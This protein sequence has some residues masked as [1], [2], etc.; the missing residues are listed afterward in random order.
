[1]VRF[2]FKTIFSRMLFLQCI[3]VF[4][5]LLITGL[6]IGLVS[7]RQGL[8]MERDLLLETAQQAF[9][10]VGQDREL[11]HFAQDSDTFIQIIENGSVKG[12]YTNPLWME[13]A[14]ID[15]EQTRLQEV[16][17]R[18]DR[19]PEGTE[20]FFC[21]SPFPIYTLYV[22]PEEG[23]ALILV[24]GDISAQNA[25]FSQVMTWTMAICAMAAFV[26]LLRSY[27]VSK[28]ILNPFVEMNHMVQCY[29]RGDFSQRIHLPGND[30]A[31]QL[32]RSFNEMADQLRNLEQTRQSFVA[33]VSHE[34]R[35]PLTSMKGFLEAM[36][37]GTIP[38]EDHEQY[39]GIVLSETRR[40]TAM[41]NDLL[42]LA[43][44]ESGIITVNY[45]VFDINE[46]IRRT[47][48][49]FEARISEKSIE[50]DVRFALEQC[51]VYADS[52]QISQVIRNL[53]DNAIKYSPDGSKLFV[54][55][56]ALR[57]EVHVT[58][59][60]TGVGIPAEDVP[61][62]FDRFYKVEKAHTP[63]PQVGSGLGLAIVKKIIE[64]HGQSIT[65]KSARGK[66]T[67]FTFTLERANPLKRVT[68]GG[69]KNGNQ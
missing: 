21:G 24:H 53:V 65:V 58:I 11:L 9:G 40:M 10:S 57:K 17:R 16:V 4:P 34:L 37:D 2:R 49:T 33:N 31:A 56:Y 8:S 44:I 14:A 41:V 30:E 60:D 47:L 52:N 64:A 29:S 62:I 6:T 22:Q 28:R 19:L 59:R 55:T 51:F 1:M 45:E 26:V 3:T 23:S 12:Y 69:R 25:A 67:Q 38:P 66:G 48:I 46:L 36:M 68:D 5:L 20:R 15:E 50:L 18:A 32:G 27:Y 61:H 7:R 13:V 54:S 35:S 39:V 43:R 42:D 63:S